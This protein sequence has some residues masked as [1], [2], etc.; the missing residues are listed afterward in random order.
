M[1]VGGRA[2]VR[3][4]GAVSGADSP[5]SAGGGSAMKGP[6]LQWNPRDSKTERP[7]AGLRSIGADVCIPLIEPKLSIGRGDE[8][9]LKL[10][11]AAVSTRHCELTWDGKRWS[12]RDLDSRN[13]T[14]VNGK[15]I[16]QRMLRS[17]DE[18]AVG[19]QQ[20]F[21]FESGHPASFAS[22][23][24]WMLWLAAAV[25]AILATMAVVYLM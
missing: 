1:Q 3:T 14:Q 2:L 8:C 17:G 24:R 15:A 12:V 25:L 18:I 13:G 4:P 22:R 10:A 16:R 21:R 5:L 9:E 23:R 19:N 11:D 6:A 20:R 7:P